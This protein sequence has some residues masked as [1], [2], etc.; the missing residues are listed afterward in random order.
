M[1][2]EIYRFRGVSI[3]HN[4][5]YVVREYVIR[6]EE[7]CFARSVGMN[8]ERIRRESFRGRYFLC[9]GRIAYEV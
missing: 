2:I 1:N 3:Q 7:I 9:G 5:S 6:G 4:H 8:W